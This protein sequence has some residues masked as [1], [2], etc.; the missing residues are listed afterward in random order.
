MI[1]EHKGLGVKFGGKCAVCGRDTGSRPYEMAATAL[2]K[3]DAG[4]FL[5]VH[6]TCA[7]GGT[8]NK[9]GGGI[10]YRREPRETIEI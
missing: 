3:T 9:I 8:K 4:K 7:G 1:A 10:V 2:Y 5:V 6:P